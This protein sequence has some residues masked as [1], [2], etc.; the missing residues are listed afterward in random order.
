MTL[1]LHNTLTGTKDVFEPLE[2]GHVR[3][4]TCGPTVWNYANVGNL[5]AFL[6]YDL[7]RRHLRV[8]GY[9]VEQVMNLT[10]IDDRILEQAMHG[11]TTIGTYTK[12]YAE[13]FFEDMRALRAEPAEHHP[14]ATEHIA[15]MVEMISTLVEHEY[16]YVSDG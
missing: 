12:P 13:A 10:D 8:S 5:R 15:E 7:V 14:R 3:M 9:A 11:S 4:Y 6:F 1:R 16:A 2:A